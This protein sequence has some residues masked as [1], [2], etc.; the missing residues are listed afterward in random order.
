MNTEMI[1][2]C[3]RMA[4]MLAPLAVATHAMAGMSQ[5]L[6]RLHGGEGAELGRCLH[7]SDEQRP[8]AR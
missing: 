5:D 4:A 1:R 2:A 3:C 7:A 8:A 6:A